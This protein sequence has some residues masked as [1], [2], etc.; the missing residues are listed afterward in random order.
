MGSVVA[1]SNTSGS[2]VEAYS[3]DVFG[4][5]TVHTAIGSDGLWFT[6]DDSTNGDTS[7]YDN[8]YM[9]TGRR[10]DN[11]TALYHYRARIYA[12]NLGRFLQ[13]TQ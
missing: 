7:Q 2:I 13:P 11:E 6:S 3:Y 8:P 9:F 12:P 10:Y 5:V 1:L 4:A